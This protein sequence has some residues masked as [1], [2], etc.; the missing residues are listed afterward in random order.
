MAVLP[1][2]GCRVQD[3]GPG[4][5]GKDRADIAPH[6]SNKRILTQRWM[7]LFVGLGTG[8]WLCPNLGNDVGTAIWV[9]TF[10]D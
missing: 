3:L 2:R 9:E 4:L 10:T 1:A 6:L 8:I 5:W 7:P